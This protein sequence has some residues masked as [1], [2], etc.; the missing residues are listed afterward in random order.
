[1]CSQ[2]WAHLPCWHMFQKC[3]HS[4]NVDMN[5]ACQFHPLTCVALP[6]VK[7]SCCLLGVV[8]YS[9]WH[10]VTSPV[11]SQVLLQ[12]YFVVLQVCSDFTCVRISNLSRL[13]SLAT[14]AV[15]SLPPQ[16]TF[17]CAFNWRPC[18]VEEISGGIVRP[19][20]KHTVQPLRPILECRNA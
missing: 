4:Q 6:Q 18:I 11:A 15:G 10:L 19:S 17:R 5:Q 7:I 12:I 1:M 13:C 3:L 14:L 2:I 16:R 8:C 9:A 20:H